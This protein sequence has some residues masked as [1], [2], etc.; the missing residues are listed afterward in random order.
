MTD[1]FERFKDELT[2]LS[3]KYGVEVS[4]NMHGDLA[5]IDLKP[6]QEPDYEEGSLKD[7]TGD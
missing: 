5:V 2:R 3:V 6:G 1:R 7:E 4:V